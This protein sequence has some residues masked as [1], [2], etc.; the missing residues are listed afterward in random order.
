MAE[1]KAHAMTAQIARATN[2]AQAI[3]RLGLRG[4]RH[5]TRMRRRNIW[6]HAVYTDKMH[7]NK[8]HCVLDAARTHDE[9]ASQ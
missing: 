8:A 7:D 1:G 5:S 3:R 6:I 4:R 9:E 2:S